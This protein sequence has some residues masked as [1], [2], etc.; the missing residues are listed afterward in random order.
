MSACQKKGCKLPTRKCGWCEDH[1][2]C[3]DN[4]PMPTRSEVR[5]LKSIV[6]KVKQ[7]R[8]D[9]A[10]G[11]ITVA[12]SRGYMIEALDEILDSAYNRGKK[13]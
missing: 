4:G 11:D 5:S 2:S 8:S 9:V 13:S 12:L 7:L 6:Q 1:C 10:K 3:A